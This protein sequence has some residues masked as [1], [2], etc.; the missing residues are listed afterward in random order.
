MRTQPLFT[1]TAALMFVFGIGFLLL[2]AAIFSLYGVDLN[3]GG[4]MLAHVAGAAVCALGTLA[5][6][7]RNST[8]PALIRP[9][10]A[11]LF[12]FFLLK[13]AVTLLAQ[14]SGVFNALG[15]TI[16]LIDIPL[17]ILYGRSLFLRSTVATPSP[18]NA[19]ARD[20]ELHRFS[21]RGTDRL[22]R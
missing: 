14:L 1:A 21:S 12:C 22:H 10:V 3:A 4:L 11:A 19:N 15:W 17:L 8:E 7:M 5:W 20:G 13:S 16:L 9:A 2:P 6:A 18:N